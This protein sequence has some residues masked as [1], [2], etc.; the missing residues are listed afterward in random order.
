M[1]R[2]GAR[3]AVLALAVAAGPLAAQRQPRLSELEARA[4]RDSLVPE[5]QYLLALGYARA[6]RHDDAA[7]ALARALTIDP[8]Y[9]PAYVAQAFQPY[10]RRPQLA[11]EERNGRVPAGWRDSLLASRRLLRQAFLLDPLAELLPPDLSRGQVRFSDAMAHWVIRRE[12]GNR[13]RD[14]LPSG[15]LWYRGMAD[16]RRG[17]FQDAI[18][19]FT[20]LLHRAQAFEQDSLAPFPVFT[21]D[22]RYILAVLYE[23]AERPGDA[24]E[25]Y[26]EALG[27]EL[28]LYM[29]HVRLAALYRRHNMWNEAVLEAQRAVETN[30]DDPT[31]LRE[32]GE[33]L[34]GAGRVAESEAPLRQAVERNRFDAGA[35]LVLAVVCEETGRRDEARDLLT[36]FLNMAP[37]SLFERQLAE[38]RWR[39][40]ALAEGGP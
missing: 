14:S 29:G 28:G 8:R 13:P 17:H 40:R 30:P 3:A 4:V 12:F 24:L 18:D 9:A 34:R 5:A 22:Y 20:T 38:A 21:N 1:A 11:K 33:T 16:A 19:D 35:V 39:L 25:L 37:A 26:K 10:R 15:A 6:K 2:P 7:H 36:R 27:H 31:A 23:R 32:L